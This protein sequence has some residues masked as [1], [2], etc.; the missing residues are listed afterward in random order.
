MQIIAIMTT[1]NPDLNLLKN[2]IKKLSDLGISLVIYDNTP[3]KDHIQNKQWVESAANTG[4]LVSYKGS[5]ENNGLSIAYNTC[6]LEHIQNDATEAFL[7]LDQDTDLDNSGL[8]SLINAYHTA[9][10]CTELGVIGGKPIRPNGA[11]YRYKS[12]SSKK[13]CNLYLDALLV[14]SSFSIIPK[15]ALLK[16]GLFQEDFFIDHIDYDFC[17]QCHRHGLA[18]LID[19]SSTFTHSVGKGDVRLFGKQICPISSPFRGYYQVRN[20]ILSAKRGGAPLPWT[21]KELIKRFI[22][23]SLNGVAD[24]NLFLRISYAVKGLR[25]G[26]SGRGGKLSSPSSP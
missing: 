15:S 14:I 8:S 10:G 3:E 22:V 12:I 18:T 25:D 19:E 24:R 20:T 13:V 23:V 9:K 1:F 17:W 4:L 11:P 26:F 16:T 7:I 6:I 21:I 5:G 2:N